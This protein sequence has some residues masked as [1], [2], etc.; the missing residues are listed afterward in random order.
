MASR[1]VVADDT[2]TDITYT[3]PWFQDQGSQ[4]TKGNFG[5]TYNSTLHGA[6]ANTASLSF[7]FNGEYLL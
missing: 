5:P 6:N 3:G 7:A 4:D 1:W 2:D